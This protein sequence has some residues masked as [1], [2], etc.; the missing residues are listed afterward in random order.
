MRQGPGQEDPERDEE[1]ARA[2]RE[3]AARK[4]RAQLWQELTSPQ[5]LW[6]LV[7][8]ALAFLVLGLPERH[9]H[10]LIGAALGAGIFSAPRLPR[11]GLRGAA[12]IAG[13]GALL[14][15]SAISW[16]PHGFFPDADWFEELVQSRKASEMLVA[17]AAALTYGVMGVVWNARGQ[18]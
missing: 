8:G 4:K 6:L 2:Q 1:Q 10:W 15:A 5:V 3:E 18:R 9:L 17:G 14:L 16:L 11:P 12:A 13:L 7:A